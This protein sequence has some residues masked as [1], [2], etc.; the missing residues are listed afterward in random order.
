MFIFL[1]PVV[2]DGIVF[3]VL[4]AVA[5]GAG[6]RGL[7]LTQCAW[8][9]GLFQL[10]YM[11]SSLVSGFRLSR[12]NAK[13]AL[14][15]SVAT[16][17]LFAVASLVARQFWPVL[18][19]MGAFGVTTGLFYNAFQTFMR[20]ESAPGRLAFATGM[21]TLSW[22][23]G[24]GL[25][26][27]SSGTLYQ[28][29]PLTLA[30]LCLL[31]GVILFTVLRLHNSRPQHLASAEEH[32]DHHDAAGAPQRAAYVWVARLLVF[33]AMFVQRPIHTFYPALSARENLAPVLASL[34]LFLHMFVQGGCG[35]A[36][37]GRLRVFYRRGSLFAVQAIA[38][39]ALLTLWRASSYNLVAM[40]IGA[41]GAWAGFSYFFAVYYASN[42]GH[43]SRNIGINECLVGLG[44]FA[45][46]FVNQWFMKWTG[47]DRVMY[48]VCGVVVLGSA[49]LQWA[50][51]GPDREK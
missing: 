7:T 28:F 6:E 18:L 50:L 8:L 4:F 9:G 22:S 19:A 20:S 1:C 44:S 14:T 21:Y 11:A 30:G 43:R 48:A 38:A 32:G 39:L 35:A 51:A 12:R 31:A 34:P 46:L 15:V 41:L 10:T 40:V 45:G 42:A 23:V 25:G 36:M 29:G 37:I 5:Y 33:T 3:L 27:L 2:M 49:V 47:D 26:F 17:I 16:S 13:G 24:S